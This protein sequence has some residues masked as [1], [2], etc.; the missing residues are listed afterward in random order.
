MKD[1]GQNVLGRGTNYHAMQLVVFQN[2]SYLPAAEDIVLVLDQLR[3]ID[4]L[5]KKGKQFL[6]SVNFEL[7]TVFSPLCSS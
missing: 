7:K 6:A 1:P 3:G 2:T 5:N 4:Y